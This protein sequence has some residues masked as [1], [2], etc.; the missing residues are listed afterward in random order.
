MRD[1]V[2][3]LFRFPQYILNKKWAL[4]NWVKKDRLGENFG[5]ISTIMP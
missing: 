5:G 4:R 2:V 1:M 3:I